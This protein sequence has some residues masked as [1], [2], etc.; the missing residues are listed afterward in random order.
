MG[1][2][3]KPQQKLWYP[4]RLGC[5]RLQRAWLSQGRG[6]P[7]VTPWVEWPPRPTPDHHMLAELQKH[8][9]IHAPNNIP[10]RAMQ[11]EYGAKRQFLAMNSTALAKRQ[12]AVLWSSPQNRV[13]EWQQGRRGEKSL[14]GV[15][16]IAGFDLRNTRM[17]SSSKHLRPTK[18]ASYVQN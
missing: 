15:L 8:A 10:F 2:P 16:E 14:H 3:C 9:A 1:I 4:L 17:Y 12:L 6:L 18:P 11:W 7:W 13:P 5:T